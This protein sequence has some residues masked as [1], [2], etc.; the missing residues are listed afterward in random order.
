MVLFKN[1]HINKKQSVITIGL[2]TGEKKSIYFFDLLVLHKNTPENI[3][4]KH[5][6]FVYY[7]T[8]VLGHKITIHTTTVNTKWWANIQIPNNAIYKDSQTIY[9]TLEF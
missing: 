2:G 5:W 9:L 4:N 1:I 7:K 8:P 6:I 3:L